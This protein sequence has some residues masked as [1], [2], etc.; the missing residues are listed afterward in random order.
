M[1]SD[2]IPSS[3][4]HEQHQLIDQSPRKED[5]WEELLSDS[6]PSAD[7]PVGERIDSRW[8]VRREFC[9]IGKSD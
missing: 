6:H 3:G 7:A 1:R 2:R 5:D 8:E 4:V 9:T